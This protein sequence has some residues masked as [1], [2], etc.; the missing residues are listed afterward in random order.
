MVGGG[1]LARMSSQA[2][3]GLGLSLRVLSDRPE[4]SAALVAART[5]TGPV[6]DLAALRA[7]AAE[8][9]VVTFDHELVPPAHL[10]AL[11]A[12]GH[13]LRP[14]PRTQRFAQ[15]KAHQRAVL[16]ALGIPVP[17]NRL[18]GSVDE[19][20]MFGDELGWPVVLK[21]VTGGYDGRGVWVFDDPRNAAHLFASGREFLVET[22]LPLDRELAVLVARRPDGESVVYPVVESVQVDGMC[23]EVIYPAPISSEV[24]E[25][26]RGLALN[27]AAAVDAV[28]VIACELF[29]VGEHVLL[30]EIAVR[31]HNSGHFTIE[32]CVTS[33]FENHIR[34]V[35]D[36]PL[37]VT[38]PTAPAAVMVNV[39]GGSTGADPVANLSAAL[40]VPGAHIHLYG[41]E[42]RPGRKLGHVTALGDDVT[43]TRARARRA[44]EILTG[45]QLPL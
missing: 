23:R 28:G 42:A 13:V 5:T 38:T 16:G 6:D 17:L 40:A 29:L 27:V 34:A 2:A 30:N 10:V 7:F 18:V 35:L 20:A 33:Q 39:V 21:A 45:E 36:W 8:C 4:D 11:E 44:A 31:P 32:G 22:F 12:E 26:A 41:K 19:L 43:E 37:G 15:D 24:A 25:H 3:I 9:D 1:Q 14:G